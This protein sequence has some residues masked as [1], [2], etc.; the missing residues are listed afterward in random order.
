[1]KQTSFP[2]EELRARREELGL[3][4]YEAFR[5]THVPA[6]Y[7]EALERGDVQALPAPC[8]A[9]GFLKSYC[10]FLGLDADR[11]VDSFRA[12]F[13]PSVVRFLTREG[14]NRKPPAWLHDLMTWAV[15]TAMLVLGWVTYT[16]VFQPQAQNPDKRVDAGSVGIQQPPAQDGHLTPR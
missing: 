2:G 4:V 16:V 14:D 8:Y 13:R 11:Y 7:I 15:I 3:T 12:C 5:R 1:M 9:V 6:N 10:E